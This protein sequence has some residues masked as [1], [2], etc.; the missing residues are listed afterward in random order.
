MPWRAIVYMCQ[1]GRPAGDSSGFSAVIISKEKKTVDL[2]IFKD[3]EQQCVYVY[4]YYTNIICIV[5]IQYVLGISIISKGSPVAELVK[6]LSPLQ[7][8]QVQFLGWEDT[9]EK[10]L[11]IHTSFLAWKIPWIE[12]PWG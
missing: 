11:A 2:S 8:T 10:E 7:K 3:K 5:D 1:Y 12:E 4:L 9:L 6:T